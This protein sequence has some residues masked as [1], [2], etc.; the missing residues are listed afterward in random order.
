MFQHQHL[1]HFYP[2]E[3]VG[4]GSHSGSHSGSNLCGLYGKLWLASNPW[5]TD[6]HII[7]VEI[8]MWFIWE[9]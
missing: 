1:Q 4:R 3:V 7:V 5:T 6:V 8:S 2:L 9:V